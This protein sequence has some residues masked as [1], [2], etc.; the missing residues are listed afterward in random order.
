MSCE[1]QLRTLGLSSLEK[2]RSRS[3]LVALYGSLR[4]EGGEGGAELFSLGSSAR[5]RGN[6]SELSQG[7]FRLDIRKHFFIKRVVKH[8]KRLPREIVEAPCLSVFKWYLDT[9]LNNML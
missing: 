7:R 2:R 1:K 4:T 8:R 5:A 9:A 6:R 3:G